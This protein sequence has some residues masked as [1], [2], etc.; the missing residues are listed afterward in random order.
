[1][2][3]TVRITLEVRLWYKCKHIVCLKTIS[4]IESFLHHYCSENHAKSMVK[5]LIFL[6]KFAVLISFTKWRTRSG[7]RSNY[8]VIGSSQDPLP[9]FSLLLSE[10]WLKLHISANLQTG[11][12]LPS[13]DGTTDW[14][15]DEVKYLFMHT[16]LKGAT[17][18]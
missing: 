10:G 2:N 8:V 1:M 17:G 5:H 9:H 12:P 18:S 16:W 13:Y 3:C 14:S 7:G 6:Q 11:E 4:H 15:N